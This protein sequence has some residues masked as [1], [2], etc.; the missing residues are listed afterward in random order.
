M[1]GAEKMQPHRDN[2]DPRHDRERIGMRA[3]KIAD[4]RGAGA[5]RDEDGGET[6]HEEQRRRELAARDQGSR[7]ARDQMLEGGAGEEAQIGRHQRQHAGREETDKPRDKGG[8]NG[9]IGHGAVLPP[10]DAEGKA[11]QA[12]LASF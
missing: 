10:R 9:D 12:T 5:E 6:E 2:G 8:R 3:Q 1:E 4:R 7:L 11:R